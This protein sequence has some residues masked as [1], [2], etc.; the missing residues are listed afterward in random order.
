[1]KIKHFTLITQS[2]SRG[3]GGFVPIK[4]NFDDVRIHLSPGYL[5]GQFRVHKSLRICFK[6]VDRS[7]Q[8]SKYNQITLGQTFIERFTEK[9]EL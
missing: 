5:A 1:M 6:P 7:I 8:T 9:T 4:L 2:L 3:L